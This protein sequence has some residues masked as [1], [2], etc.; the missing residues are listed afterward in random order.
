MK[1]QRNKFSIERDVLIRAVIGQFCD[2]WSLICLD[3]NLYE[4][5]V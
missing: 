2:K 3:I 4:N 5:K 1:N